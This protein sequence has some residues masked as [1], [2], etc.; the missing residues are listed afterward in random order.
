M[1]VLFLPS[2][3]AQPAPG[4]KTGPAR[5]AAVTEAFAGPSVGCGKIFST[6]QTAFLKTILYLL[7]LQRLPLPLEDEVAVV[8]KAARS[9]S[10]VDCQSGR[11]FSS[12]N[13]DSNYD[14]QRNSWENALGQQPFAAPHSLTS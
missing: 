7:D 9:L 2:P 14:A 12:E 5:G 4:S 10:F 6:L 1:R 11:S 3:L 13:R 8:G